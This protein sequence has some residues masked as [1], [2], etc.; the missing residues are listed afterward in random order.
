MVV[1]LIP[2]APP[3]ISVLYRLECEHRCPRVPDP[4]ICC[5]HRYAPPWFYS[6]RGRTLIPLSQAMGIAAVYTLSLVGTNVVF[7]NHQQRISNS[8]FSC[9]LA[10][11]AVC[12]G[13]CLCDALVEAMSN[14]I[15]LSRSHCVPHLADPAAD[16]RGQDGLLQPYKSRYHRR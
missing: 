15:F 5:R 13:A 11:N 12:T 10:L 2:N 3:A 8:F 14:L 4:S 6:R 7:N 1:I 16:A 9:T